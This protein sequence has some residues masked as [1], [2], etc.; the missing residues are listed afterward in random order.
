MPKGVYKVPIP[1]N[2]PVLYYAPGSKERARLQQALAKARSVEIDVPM[3]IGSDEVTTD[4]KVRLSPPHDHQHVL[5][6]FNE[7]DATHV[8]QAINAALGAKSAWANLSWEH[9]ASIFLKAADLIA[10][11]YR[12]RLNAATMLGQSKNAYQ[13]EIDSACEIIDFLRFNVYYMSQIYQQQPESAP[14]IWNRLE[15]R[16]LE[17]F[18]FALTPFNFTAIAGNLP[19]WPCWETPRY[20]SLPI[21]RFMRLMF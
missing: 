14:G 9:R 13:A 1:R 10:G 18:V 15:Q 12:A 4:K 20:G 7:G 16:P 2:E 6:Y 3:Y 17:G 11:P 19:V 21:P 5:G 8:E